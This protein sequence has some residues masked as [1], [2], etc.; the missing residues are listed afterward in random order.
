MAIGNVSGFIPPKL[1]TVQISS[2]DC[3]KYGIDIQDFYKIDKNEDGLIDSDEFLSGGLG[4]LSVF[5]AFKS[6][7][8]PMGAY[9]DPQSIGQDNQANGMNNQA[10]AFNSNKQNQYSLQHPNVTNPG[11]ANKCDFLA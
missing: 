8:E 6:L 10:N 3:K 4:N 1:S 2:D 5:N 7:A 9:Q 11:F